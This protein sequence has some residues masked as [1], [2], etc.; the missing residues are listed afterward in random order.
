LNMKGG[1]RDAPTAILGDQL[2]KIDVLRV[3]S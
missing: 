1:T 2:V 3:G